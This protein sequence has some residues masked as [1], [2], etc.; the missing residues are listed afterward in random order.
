MQLHHTICVPVLKDKKLYVFVIGVLE[1]P[2]VS[3][4]NEQ[5]R[6]QTKNEQITHDDISTC[7]QCR[8]F[9]VRQRI[10]CDN[11]MYR[12]RSFRK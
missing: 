6:F 7:S 12:A 4:E 1:R 2:P 5:K 9:S 10:C 8:G 11:K 3:E